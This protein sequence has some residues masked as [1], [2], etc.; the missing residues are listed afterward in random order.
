MKRIAVF[1]HYSKNNKIEDYVVFYLESLKKVADFTVFVSDS[2]IDED[3]ISKI[4]PFTDKIIAKPHGEYDFGS[5]KRGYL[6]LKEAGILAP[7]NPEISELIFAND[8]CYAPLFPFDTMFST[9]DTKE[10]DFWGNTQNYTEEIIGKKGFE[11]IQSYFLVFRQNVFNSK[12]FDDFMINITKEN[13]KEDIINKYEIGLST[14]LKKAGF[15]AD[16]YCTLSKEKNDVQLSNY[17]SIVKQNHSPFLKRGLV[18]FRFEDNYPF[19]IKKLIKNTEYDYSLI[20]KDIRKNR[21]K[22][23]VPHFLCFFLKSLFRVVK[24]KILKLFSR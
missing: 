13:S 8:S 22:F 16:A 17:A 18:L 20:E 3:E 5:Y 12:A 6:Y 11:H 9:M 21:E 4:S 15:K 10:V 24:Y 7:K 2:N 23:T 1:A 14:T 19:F